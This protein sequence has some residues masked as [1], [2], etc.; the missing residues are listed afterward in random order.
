MLAAVKMDD[1]DQDLLIA[2]T[3]HMLLGL[4]SKNRWLMRKWARQGVPLPPLYSSGVV[5]R[6]DTSEPQRFADCIEVLEDRAGCC[7]ALS[8]YRVAEL[9]EADKL[10]ADSYGFSVRAVGKLGARALVKLGLDKNAHVNLIHVKVILANGGLEDP[11]ERLN[12]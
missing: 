10:G 7:K 2:Q 12:R 8:A 6:A 11:S 5:Y 4:A 9:Q 1:D 3:H